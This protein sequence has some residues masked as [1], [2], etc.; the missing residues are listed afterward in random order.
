MWSLETIQQINNK[1]AELS[2]NGELDKKDVL[3]ECGISLPHHCVDR[4]KKQRTEQQPNEDS[5]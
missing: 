2:R 5:K 1:V 4:L 3:R